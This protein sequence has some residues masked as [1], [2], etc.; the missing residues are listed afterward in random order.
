MGTARLSRVNELLR[1]EIAEVLHRLMDEQGF[2]TSTM[3]VT[4]VFTSSDLR[5]ARVLISI[6]GDTDTCQMMLA[7]IRRER[8]AV[9]DRIG[10]D[11]KLK[12]T[13]RLSF[14]YDHSLA[15]GDRVLRII[16]KLE[17]N[18]SGVEGDLEEDEQED[19]A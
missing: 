2:D 3:T 19:G 15:A 13:P 1:R 5:R 9:Q 6:R 10:R 16:D 14:E 18:Q 12:Y 4:Q 17:S 11:I 7:G 8:K